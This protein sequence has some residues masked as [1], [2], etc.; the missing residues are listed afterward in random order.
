MSVSNGYCTAAE[1]SRRLS[2]DGV[3]ISAA[4]DEEL[5]EAI[6]TACRAIDAYCH[7]RFIVDSAATARE[8]DVDRIDY[9]TYGR[10]VINVDSLQSGTITAVV[11]DDGD[12]GTYGTT[13]T[14]STDYYT[15]PLNAI[16]ERGETCAITRLVTTGT[17]TVRTSGYRP[18]F[19]V[20]AKWGWPAIPAPVKAA[21]LEV[22]ADLVKRR[23]APFGVAGF[24]E[25]GTV[26]I[27]N[28]VLR[29]VVSLLA[30]YRRDDQMPIVSVS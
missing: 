29:R 3:A 15:W 24:G 27:S 21:A 10:Q 28:D 19:K 11:S 30:P 26:R 14:A 4:L 1:L 13:W 22:A 2:S 20:T 25:F 9:D 6:N 16:N 5:D 12:T 17:K 8:F 23:E 7:Q 18:P